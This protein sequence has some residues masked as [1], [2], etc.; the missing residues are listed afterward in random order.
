VR[1]TKDI[2]IWI[3]ISPE[4]ADHFAA[5]MRRF[6]GQSPARERLLSKRFLLRMGVPPNMIE[7]MTD[8]SGVEFADCY[9]RRQQIEVDG[10][11]I[12]IL[13]L[14]DLRRNKAASGRPQDL[15]DLD[16]LPDPDAPGSPGA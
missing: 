12:P 10:I 2:D 11:V 5:A 7:V 14:A 3:A 9:A 8:I 16:H 6:I 13:H 1:A 4:N 15:G